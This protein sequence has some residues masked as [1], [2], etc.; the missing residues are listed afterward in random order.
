MSYERLAGGSLDYAPCRYG[1]SKLLFR[2]PRASLREPYVAFLG[3]TETYGKFVA[4]PFPERV[5]RRTGVTA[6]NLG[7]VN[8]GVDTFHDDPTVQELARGARAAVIQVMGADKLSNRLYA[9]HPRRNDRFLSESALL[10]RLYPEAEFTE[11]HFTCHLLRMLHGIDRGRFAVVREEL[12]AAWMSRMSALIERL[13]VPVT[14][15]WVSPKSPDEA[16]GSPG[17]PGPLFVTRAMLDGLAGRIAELVEIPVPPRG[18]AETPEGMVCSDIEVPAALK[19]PGPDIHA[20]IAA[21]L[22]PR[23]GQAAAV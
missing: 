20:R 8:A 4:T 3:S 2:G 22:S 5:G 15:L 21:A 10:R 18:D 19:L 14:L 17:G 12:Q 13:D 7:C 23:L 11:I 9:V 1:N 16:A 6:L